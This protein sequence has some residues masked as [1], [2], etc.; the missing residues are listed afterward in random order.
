MWNAGKLVVFCM[1]VR[2]TAKAAQNLRTIDQV[3]SRIRSKTVK[4]VTIAQI[5]E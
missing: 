5:K 4:G 1:E 2:S 3:D